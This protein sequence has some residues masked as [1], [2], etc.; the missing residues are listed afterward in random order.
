MKIL[1]AFL[2]GLGDDERGFAHVLAARRT[3]ATVPPYVLRLPC[4][5]Y[6]LIPYCL[7][8]HVVFAFYMYGNGSIFPTETDTS[9]T[10]D[11][12]GKLKVKVRRLLCVP[13]R[14]HHTAI[15]F[16]A[17]HTRC[18]CVK[19]TALRTLPSLS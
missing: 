14:L 15:P 8:I 2:P 5:R 17:R 6:S 10:F 18:P 12:S 3:D 11:F 13:R 4:A 16:A 7:W 9:G 19:C 1:A